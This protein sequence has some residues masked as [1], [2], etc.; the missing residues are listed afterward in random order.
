MVRAAMGE[1]PSGPYSDR[2]TLGSA[3][4][5]SRAS[6]LRPHE[7]RLIAS[8][9][10]RAAP[11]EDSRDGCPY[12]SMLALPSATLL[13]ATLITVQSPRFVHPT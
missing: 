2:R 11:F 6:R 3:L 8:P 10:R 1:L 9:G 4:H 5:L 12:M 7:P 13:P